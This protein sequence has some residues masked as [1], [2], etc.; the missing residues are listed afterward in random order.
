VEE[1]MRA[2]RERQ[3]LWVVSVLIAVACV[4][5]PA[6]AK[7]GGGNGTADDPY[8]IWTAEQ[9]NAIGAEP[10]DWDKHFQLRADLDLSGFDGRE[11]RPA[12]NIIALDVDADRPWSQRAFFTGVF[13]GSGHTI[14]HFT[15]VSTNRFQHAGLFGLVG[16]PRGE[17]RNLGLVDAMVDVGGG[18]SV[19]ALVGTNDGVIVHCY[20]SGTV[21]SS[22]TAPGT[23]D[24]VGEL[25]GSNGGLIAGCYSAGTVTGEG[26][27]V[28]GLVGVH[29]EGV[30]TCCYSTAAVSSTHPDVAGLVGVCFEAVSECYSTGVVSGP[31]S[32]IS[33]LVG[34]TERGALGQEGAV[35]NSFWDITT[36]LQPQS[37]RGTGLTTE[38]MQDV[39]TYLEAGWDWSGTKEDGTAEVWQMPAGGGYPVL[40][41]FHG[42]VPPQLQ[43]E[44]TPDSP[45][46]ITTTEDLGAMH[47]YDPYAHYRLASSLD[48]SG[49]RWG[50]AVIPWFG[51]VF[52]GN[53]LTIS[54]LTIAGDAYLGLFGQIA[55]G[56]EVRDLAVV[57][58]N[59]VGSGCYVAAL[60]AHNYGTILRCYSTGTVTGGWKVAGLAGGNGRGGSVTQCYSTAAV[61]GGWCLGGLV[62]E[63]A[64]AV[65]QC[66]S[67]S[68]GQGWS[69]PVAQL[70]GM[71]WGTVHGCFCESLRSGPYGP[72][73]TRSL[74]VAATPGTPMQDPQTYLAAGWDWL[75]ETA[76]GTSEV[77]QMP[78]GGGYPVLSVFSGYTPA[79]LPGRGTAEDPYLVSDAN[80]LGAVTYYSPDR[81][82]RLAAPIDLSGIRWAVPVMSSFGGSFDGA[83]LAIS[84][85]TIAGGGQVGLFGQLVSVA[86]VRDLNIVDANVI[87]SGSYV[88]ALAGSKRG[89]DVTRCHGTGAVKGTQYVGGLAG[90]NAWGD[91]KDC[92]STS[93]VSGTEQ[94]GGLLGCNVGR[95]TGSAS[96]GAIRGEKSVGGLVGYN[97]GS[98]DDCHNA[99]AVEGTRDIG[100]LVGVN[101]AGA[102]A[103][104]DNR[105]A[106]KGLERVGGLVGSSSDQWYQPVYPGAITDSFSVGPVVGE[107]QVGG[108]LGSSCD[109]VTNSHSSGPVS[110]DDYVG[111]LVGLNIGPVTQSYSAGPVDGNEAIGGLAGGNQ[112]TVDRSRSEGTVRGRQFV[113]GLVGFSSG[114]ITNCRSTAC[115]TGDVNDVGGL[116]GK[117]WFATIT[118]SCACNVVTG[119]ANDVG[120]LVGA[121]WAGRMINCYSTSTI[122]GRDYVGGLL[123]IDWRV[124]DDLSDDNTCRRG[125]VLC[126]YSAGQISGRAK[127][128]GFVGAPGGMY[129]SYFWDRQ[130][131]GLAEMF[132]EPDPGAIGCD[133]RGGKTTAEMQTAGTFLAVGW[134]FAGETANGTE[135]IWLIEEGLD[136]PHLWWEAAGE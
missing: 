12:F 83:S 133:N 115:V 24:C 123:G 94:I 54:H 72:G 39:Q 129:A 5:V 118:D 45:Y 122:T 50:A 121:N 53:G 85:L 65:S 52:D 82:Y 60:A 108:L 70:V 27:Y 49:I 112:G 89:G 81:H 33:G 135:D 32:F 77:W 80:G 125:T 93:T 3:I 132:G 43:G 51:G 55:R 99:A 104:C 62:G 109:A 117:N 111:G 61:Q 42:Y 106:V 128:G 119:E 1:N 136:Y 114:T 58:V 69:D 20:S 96:A 98:L 126:C 67:A 116:V 92:N 59:V 14:A 31:G 23:G 73:R 15:H 25:V 6:R 34:Y 8:Q 100:G 21:H 29:D 88:G 74:G 71:D 18:W 11:G 90:Y 107:R 124:C 64:G 57:D 102:V 36:S 47:Y 120:G 113:G 86:R 22:G 105:G 103:G 10:N 127:V 95:V 101:W 44:G 63:N 84:H 35:S 46:L 48:L 110:G 37:V 7:Y 38:Q 9:M 130:V 13:D 75:G 79:R 16:G 4:N 56:A 134:D 66:Y 68:A 30:I 41:F 28:G 97:S 91:L 76:N 2:R 26:R 40:A 87:G 19:G 131:S 78:E 17:I